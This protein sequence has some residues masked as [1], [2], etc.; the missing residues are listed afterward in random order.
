MVLAI[1][2]IIGGL[3]AAIG[4][5]TKKSDDAAQALSKL[6]PYQG[7]IGLALLVYGLYYL[8][9]HMIPNLGTML[10]SISGILGIATLVLMILVGFI[11]SYGLVAK[12]VLPKNEEAQK[13]GAETLAKLI[14]IQAPLGIALAI[15]AVLS[16]VL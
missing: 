8:I 16:L 9:F 4:L 7:W 10:T 3:L 6:A 1:L 12:Y 13:K 2:S 14:P 15:C 11:L 5:V